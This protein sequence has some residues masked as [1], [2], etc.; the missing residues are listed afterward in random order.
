MGQKK[1]AKIINSFNK[2]MYLDSLHSLQPEGTYREA[3]GVTNQT[4]DE[5]KYGVSNEAANE[6]WVKLPKGTIRS[7]LYIEERDYYVAFMKMDSGLSEIGIINEKTKEYTKVVDDNNLD[8]PMN[9]SNEEWNSITS[10]VMQPCNELHVYWS[11]ADY[12]YRVNL[13]DKCHDWKLHPIKLFREHCIGAIQSTILDGGGGGLPNGI[14]QPF[15]RLRDADGNTT[16]WFKMGQPI[17]IGQG[18]D[19][20]NIAGENSGKSINIK[21][22]NLHQDYGVADIG[23]YSTVGGRAVAIWIDTVAY[24]KGILDYHYRGVTGKEI[25]ILPSEV[26]GRNDLYIR[27]KN[28]T[29]YDG[30]LILYSLRANNNVDWQRDVSKFKAYYQIYAVP[31]RDAHRY[32]GLRP[33]ENYWFGIHGN[34]VDGNKTADFNFIG[35]DDGSTF[36]VVLPGCDCSVPSWEVQDTSI[37]TKTFCD[38]A[39][40]NT[41]MQREH[42]LTEDE[43][44]DLVTEYEPNKDDGKP[45]VVANNK[46]NADP[47]EAI[48]TINKEKNDAIG[49]A[50]GAKDLD[51]L[52]CMCDNFKNVLEDARDLGGGD[53]EKSTRFIGIDNAEL[54]QLA[55][56]CESIKDTSGNLIYP[57][58]T[59]QDLI[60]VIVE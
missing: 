11:N 43:G 40:M 58:P 16:N 44:N 42:T 5:N 46:N 26:I 10:K 32:K 52:R 30:H 31:V 59:F 7:L 38:L 15:L 48:E 55:C 2:G 60:K 33:N 54:Y 27:G 3:W 4:D 23:I 34:Y 49:A 14:Y 12:Y 6:L 28:L 39:G 29:Q 53:L 45:P 18:H 25:P 22:E 51:S 8:E 47:T 19:G 56:A 9:F 13:D 20:D 35:R 17:P 50:G 21:T 24:G 41:S 36:S 57:P 37:R 1:K